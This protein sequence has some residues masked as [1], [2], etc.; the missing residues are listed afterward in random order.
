MTQRIVVVH[1][2]EFGSTADVAEAIGATLR[3]GGA[4]VDVQ[5]VVNINDVRRYDAVII[6][7]A[8]YN[9]RW[10][11]EAE[12]FVRF[13][14]ATLSRIPVAYFCVSATMREDTPENRAAARSFLD[15]VLAAAPEV[16]PVAI[17]L[18][19][20]RV[21]THGL[22]P[23]CAAATTATGRRSAPGRLTLRR[24]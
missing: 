19:A 15:P 6:G 11:P 12:N 1:A 3:E 13:H 2:S 4:A 7:S 24:C 8:I 21:E 22:P 9:G 17:G 14:A 18:F 10:L 20:G 16:R 23:D 5:P